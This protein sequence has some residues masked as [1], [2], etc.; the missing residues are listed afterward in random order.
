MGNCGESEL[1]Y[2]ISGAE[3]A[4]QLGFS[5]QPHSLCSLPG[6]VAWRLLDQWLQP[7]SQGH[8]AYAPCNDN[9]VTILKVISYRNLRYY[10]GRVL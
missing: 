4:W 1:L 7:S 8:V 2:V 9:C 10:E 5:R 3:Q 6:I